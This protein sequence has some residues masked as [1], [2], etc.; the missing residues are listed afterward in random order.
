MALSAQQRRRVAWLIDG[1]LADDYD[2]ATHESRW[3]KHFAAIASPE[4]LYLFASA[5]HPNQSPKEWRRILD[6]P[7]CDA[8]TALLIF[9]RN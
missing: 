8:G 3:E 7:L 4:E 5:S 9:G 1:H 6:N 2:E